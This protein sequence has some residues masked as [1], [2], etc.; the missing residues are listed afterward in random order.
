MYVATV[1]L[2]LLP[3]LLLTLSWKTFIRDQTAL[4][5]WRAGITTAT[6][7][8]ALLSTVIHFAWNISWL[9][10][11]GSPHGMGAGPGVWMKLGRPLLWTFASAILGAFFAKGKCRLFL[12]GWAGSMYLVFQPI[13]IF[14]ME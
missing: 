9:H 12:L 7:L 6:L 11:G 1:I 5:R 2:F 3:S 14:Q 10:A 13:Y 4:V 8:L